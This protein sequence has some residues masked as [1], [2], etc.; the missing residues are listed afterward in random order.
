MVTRK[1]NLCSPFSVLKEG[2]FLKKLVR[3]VLGL[4]IVFIFLPKLEVWASPMVEEIQVKGNQYIDTEEI[5]Q[6]IKSKVDE[7]LS[8]QRI[9]EDIQAIYDMGFFSYLS[10]LKEKEKDGLILIF[11][12]E[13]NEIINEISFE[14]IEGKEVNKIKK[15]LTFKERDLFNFIEVKK[16]KDKI[17]QFYY[18]KGFLAASVTI[19]NENDESNGCKVIVNIQKGEVV[20]VKRVEIKGNSSFSDSQVMALMKA[21]YGRFFDQQILEEDLKKIVHFYQNHG[22]YFAYFKSP[23]FEFSEE[24]GI[25]WVTVFLEIVEGRQFFVSQIEIRGENKIFSESEIMSQFKPSKGGLFVP[26]YIKDSINFLQDKYGERGYIHIRIKSDLDFDREG[27]KVKVLLQIEE[28]PQVSIGK[29]R[30]E[31]N[32]LSQERI[33]K[34]AFTL[35]EGD[36]FDIKEAREGWRRLY[37]LGF[38]ENVEIEPIAVSSSIVD[39][40]IKVKEIERQGQFYIGGGYNTAS[41]LQGE[42]QFFK[43]NLWGEGKRIGIDWQFA[44]KKNE[45]NITY[46]DR[47]WGDTSIRLEPRIYKRKDI[48]NET[49]GDYE[50]E[51]I[52]IEMKIGKPIWKFSNIYI[53]L[54]DERIYID[55]GVN[56]EISGETEEGEKASHSL[57]FILDRNT[58]V[59]DEAFNPYQGSYSYISADITGGPMLG[60]EF[61]FTKYRGEWRGYLRKSSFWKYPVIA[62]RLRVKTGENLPVYEKFRIG[63][64]ETLRGYRQNEFI[65]EEL[66][67]GNFELRLPLDKNFLTYLFV[68][69]GQIRNEDSSIYKAGWGFGIRIKTIIGFIRLDYGIGEE[70]GQLYFGMGEGF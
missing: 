6:V 49:D 15:L 9:R 42:I 33:F 1:D 39:L 40:L 4:S 19:F 70:G 13:E 60:G 20:R 37:N 35:K 25:E 22:Y 65:G 7:P 24:K 68:D 53:S 67:L 46:L 23:D 64:M 28:G 47:W 54:R 69:A 61:T 8:E 34:H 5:L 14:G 41:G 18:K 36:I 62:C 38:F 17:S 48:Y 31:G 43:D 58:R 44:E 51:T 12:V 30:I 52:G 21:R 32:E 55:E 45:Y 66:I 57:T 27:G 56:G 3:I 63:G 10:A 50:K 29:I 59:R 11:Q 2:V 26:D 16:S